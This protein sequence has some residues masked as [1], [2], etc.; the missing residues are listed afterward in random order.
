MRHARLRLSLVLAVATGSTI[1]VYLL[2]PVAQD[3]AYHAFADQRTLVGIP[4]ALNVLSNLAFVAVGVVGLT[5]LRSHLVAASPCVVEARD[6]LPYRVFFAGLILT[7][8]GSA[9]YHLAPDS[10][11]L[12]WDRL[13][14]TVAFMGLLASVLGERMAPRWG[15]WGLGLLLWVG[16]ASVLYWRWTASAGAG[17]LRPYALVQYLPVLLIPLLIALFPGRY[18]RAGDL[19]GVI[20]IYAVA[21]ALE[22]LDAPILS[23]GQ[24]ASG[25]TFKHLVAAGAGYWVLRMVQ[26]RQLSSSAPP[27]TP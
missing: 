19:L 3:P 23:L 1:G 21:K 17:D 13:P 27:L 8:L 25:H 26:H 9:W 5:A 7:G 18:T 6:L 20:G 4:H 14:M 11:R 10:A 12:T 22:A 24:I 15:R 2:P 16:L